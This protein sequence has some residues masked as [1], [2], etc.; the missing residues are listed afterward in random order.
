M[1]FCIGCDN[2]KYLLFT[3]VVISSYPVFSVCDILHIDFKTFFFDSLNHSYIIQVYFKIQS[4]GVSTATEVFI[5]SNLG[6]GNRVLEVSNINSVR[7]SSFITEVVR[8][9]VAAFFLINSKLH[10]SFII[11][12]RHQFTSMNE[13]SINT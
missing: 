5:G 4:I 3:T 6:T 2:F 1:S 10:N 7:I 8:S 12:S 9:F 13:N 11:N